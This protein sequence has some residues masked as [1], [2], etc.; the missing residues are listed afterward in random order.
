MLLGLRQAANLGVGTYKVKVLSA[1]NATAAQYVLT[2]KVQPPSCGDT[3]I[4]AGEQC[5]DGNVASGDGCSA[6][7]QSE[8]PWEIEPN[9]VLNNATGA[10][11]GFGGWNGSIKTIGDH[12]WFKF[13]VMTGQSVTLNVHTIGDAASCPFDSKIHLVNAGGNEVIQDDDGG[14]GNCSTISPALYG[15]AANL[16]GG[17][18]YVWVQHFSDASAAGPYQ[19]DLTVQ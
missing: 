16:P 1:L 8:A 19:I 18:Y 17:A 15:A 12:D 7:C 9:D 6:M 14:V 2:V 11:A 13:L 5:D 3:L 10:W 4:S